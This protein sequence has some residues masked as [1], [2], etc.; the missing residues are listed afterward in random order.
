MYNL[1]IRLL[2]TFFVVTSHHVLASDEEVNLQTDK[3][4]WVDL[5][6]PFNSGVQRP[7]DWNG[8]CDNDESLK[9]C[10]QEI[11][12]LVRTIEQLRSQKTNSVDVLLKHIL[13][14]F[15]L[16]L[17]VNL[18]SGEAVDRHARV[19][20]SEQQVAIVV[21]YLESQK[22]SEEIGRRE[23]LREVLE[24][25]LINDDPG[26]GLFV[27]FVRWLPYLCF[28]NV[29]ILPLA[30]LVILKQLTSMRR[31]FCFALLSSFCCSYYFTYIRKYQEVLASRFARSD[32]SN[33][34]CAP[35]GLVAETV[36]VLLSYVK[37]KGKNRC[38]QSHEDM[39]I[40][41]FLL[42]DPLQVFGEVIT[43]F[44]MSPFSVLG[45]HLNKFFADFF[46]R[47][48]HSFDSCKIGL[49]TPRPFLL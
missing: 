26:S 29:L 24:N 42:V 18:N 7:S 14:Q 44:I 13:R 31:L 2:I 6:D 27:H 28:L 16:K 39:L 46:Y 11:E 45:L 32:F 3:S 8:N 12:K 48:S 33:D 35:K 20:L 10:K 43:N 21:N 38:L 41:P 22:E 5:F 30:I 17:D 25:F 47:Y 49:H 4:G 40:E 19:H 37:I 15:F 34:H 23:R 36:D 1:L 9:E